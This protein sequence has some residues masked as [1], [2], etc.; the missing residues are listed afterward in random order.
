MAK[1]K[2]AKKNDARHTTDATVE[3]TVPRKKKKRPRHPS[4]LAW[5][6]VLFVDLYFENLG[7][8]TAAASQAGYACPEVK[9]SQLLLHVGV[10][11]E[12]ARRSAILRKGSDEKFFQER[13]YLRRRAGTVVSDVVD[14]MSG[15]VALKDVSKLPRY[16]Q[17]AI[18]SISQTVT[19]RGVTTKVTM[20]D[21]RADFELIWRTEGRLQPESGDAGAQD[22]FLEKLEQMHNGNRD[23]MVGIPANADGDIARA[24][25]HAD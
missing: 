8:A 19:K 1:K 3:R 7:N 17:A 5:K 11:A 23:A 10:K 20:H 4:G 15:L 2:T 21:A 13:N 14:I 22:A 6:H 25:A 12:I 16:Q 18:K 9:G 24:P